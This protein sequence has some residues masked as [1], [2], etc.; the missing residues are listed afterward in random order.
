MFP[1]EFP[2]SSRRVPV[3]F[4]WSSYMSQQFYS[5]ENYSF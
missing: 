5:V 2:Q 1:V 3:E 4:P